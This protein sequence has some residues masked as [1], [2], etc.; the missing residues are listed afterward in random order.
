MGNLLSFGN[1]QHTQSMKGS[2][3]LIKAY[4]RQYLCSIIPLEIITMI[5]QYQTDIW[6]ISKS[7]V[8][9]F[10]NTAAQNSLKIDNM[11]AT[12]EVL[13]N[14]MFGHMN[15]FSTK[16]VSTGVTH[17]KIG[18]IC[19]GG[20]CIGIIDSMNI[21][22]DMKL[23]YTDPSSMKLITGYLSY[24]QFVHSYGY[25]SDGTIYDQHKVLSADKNSGFGSGD[26]IEII[27]DLNEYTLIVKKNGTEIYKLNVMQHRKYRLA[28]SAK[29]SIVRQRYNVYR[30]IN[31][32]Y[33]LL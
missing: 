9:V 31:C 15:A 17:W 8:R 32:K 3:Y 7:N 23:E 1:K 29:N 26:V 16:I 22:K 5:K 25:C 10:Y 6:D 20:M 19:G 13:A 28:V 12:V 14:P 21:N 2:D 18:I 33:K 27:L 30:C 24:M 11:N 4:A